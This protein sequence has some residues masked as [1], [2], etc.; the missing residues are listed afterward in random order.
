[1]A[2]V[3]VPV[4][5]KTLPVLSM[6]PPIEMVLP[7]SASI[8][9][10]VVKLE[11]YTSSVPPFAASSVPL[12]WMLSASTR[13]RAAAHAGLDGPLVD[14]GNVAVRPAGLGAVAHVAVLALDRDSR[15]DGQRPAGQTQRIVMGRCR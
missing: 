8:V 11:L 2:T 5:A 6:V 13:D 14:H 7:A 9:P 15:G 1:M 10:V 4:G 3:P 12:F